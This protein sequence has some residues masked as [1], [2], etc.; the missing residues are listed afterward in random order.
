MCGPG[1]GVWK[2]RLG[3][4]SCRACAP[5]A[6][7]SKAC[8]T[9]S[10]AGSAGCPASRISAILRLMRLP[11]THGSSSCALP[12]RRLRQGLATSI[13]GTILSTSTTSRACTLPVRTLVPVCSNTSSGARNGRLLRPSRLFLYQNTLRMAGVSQ[14][15]LPVDLRTTLKAMVR[16]GLPPERYWPYEI[17]R[18][19]LQPDP[20]LYSYS[21]PCR[22]VRY[23]RLDRRGASGVRTLQTVKAFLAA[24]FPSAFGFPVP[25]SLSLNPDIPYR[26]TFDTL[27]GGQAVIAVGYD[28]RWLRGS[29]GALLVRSSW[30]SAVWR[31]RVRVAAVRLCGRTVGRRFLDVV[32]SGL[33]HVR[34]VRPAG[35]ARVSPE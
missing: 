27:I 6:S 1:V 16:C 20:F 35:S 33:D 23:V 8:H 25:N 3:Q 18:L 24:G 21:E 29:R 2:A 19:S 4:P 17:D 30:G 14:T 31:E 26:P 7:R 22:S 28:D 11:P 15:S 34:R 13:C 10:L 9:S 32:P 12:A 5:F